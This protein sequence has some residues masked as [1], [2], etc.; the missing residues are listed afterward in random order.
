MSLGHAYSHNGDLGGANFDAFSRLRVSNPVTLLDST[1]KYDKQETLWYEQLTAGGL[2]SHVYDSA[3]ASMQVATLGDKVVRQTREYFRY[4]PGKSQLM[5]C[6][7]NLNPND[8]TGGVRRRV[9]YFD[10]ENGIYVELTQAGFYVVR[11]SSSTGSV[12]NTAVKQE[13]WN[14][15]SL[16][17]LDVTKTQIF[18]IDLQWLGVGRVRVGFVIDGAVRYIHEFNH[19]N[20]EALVYMTTAQLPVRYEIEATG[21]PLEAST[22]DQIC[23]AVMSE[24]GVELQAG[25][26]HSISSGAPASV[27]GT[28]VPILSIRPKALFGGEV[29]RI[30]TIQ[31]AVQVINTGNGTAEVHVIWDGTLTG[32]AFASVEDDSTIE[33]D[34]AAT[35]VTGGHTVLSFYVPASNQAA[36]ALTTDI[37]GKLATTLDIDGANPTAFTIAITNHGTVDAAAAMTWQEYQ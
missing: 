6:T 5:L 4:Q 8:E 16:A 15:D 23:A 22:L 29:N 3:S 31:R 10:G 24:G 13:N 28:R 11:R 33:S 2:S 25:I 12:V 37:A 21:E 17:E 30:Q 1:L 20:N 14:L 7:F 32:A 26:P 36:S 18:L 9:G 34:V 27:S 19:A 35:A